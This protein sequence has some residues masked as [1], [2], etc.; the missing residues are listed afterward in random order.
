[1]L[2]RP[3]PTTT[4]RASYAARWPTS[5]T[6]TAPAIARCSSGHLMRTTVFP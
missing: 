1:M 5:K 6:H 3:E 2:N 4:P